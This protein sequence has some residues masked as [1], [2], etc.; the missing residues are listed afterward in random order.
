MKTDPGR[1]AV[2]LVAAGSLM[3][4]ACNDGAAAGAEPDP[5]A[6]AATGPASAAEFAH[7]LTSGAIV[8]YEP[9]K[10]AA[11]AV[12]MADVIVTGTIT[13][14]IDNGDRSVVIEIAVDETL[15]GEPADIVHLWH[16]FEGSIAGVGKPVKVTVAELAE[17]GVGLRVAA[18]AVEVQ[19]ADDSAR[20]TPP[21][22]LL[23]LPAVD[24]FFLQGSADT[25]MHCPYLG[26]PVS[27]WGA[28][29]IDEYAELIRPASFPDPPVP[30]Q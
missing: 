22:A 13:D 27:M 26:Y 15:Y 25:G 8:D 21:Y 30:G 11:E 24:A 18:S 12:A 14:V 5:T 10:S 3:L 4:S 1:L 23:R 7:L 29:T 17:A 20:A 9:T 28:K 16:E 6:G 19:S 2:A